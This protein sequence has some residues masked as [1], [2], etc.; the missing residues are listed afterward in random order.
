VEGTLLD[1][2]AIFFAFWAKPTL[3]TVAFSGAVFNNLDGRGSLD[4]SAIGKVN[5]TI[6]SHEDSFW[7]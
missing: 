5:K 1:D 3:E 4:I 6:N 7:L 2:W